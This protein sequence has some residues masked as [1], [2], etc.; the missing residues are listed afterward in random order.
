MKIVLCSNFDD[1]TLDEELVCGDLNDEVYAHTILDCLIERYSGD[2]AYY[3]FKLVSDE[4]ELYR[5][6][7]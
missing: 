2:S 5:F 1:P 6:E 7:P 4:Y 3:Y